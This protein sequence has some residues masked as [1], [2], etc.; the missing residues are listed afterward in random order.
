MRPL[1]PTPPC[2]VPRG[3]APALPG[4]LSPR[5]SP[6]PSPALSQ[7]RAPSSRAFPRRVPRG[8]G[9]FFSASLSRVHLECPPDPFPPGR[10][11]FPQPSPPSVPRGPCPLPPTLPAGCSPCLISPGPAYPTSPLMLGVPGCA[12]PLSGAPNWG[13]LECP[14]AAP[15]ARAPALGPLLAGGPARPRPL[16][17]PAVLGGALTHPG[18]G[19]PVL[20]RQ[21]AAGAECRARQ[22]D[23]AGP[24]GALR[25][26]L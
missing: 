21:R 15:W 4:L 23:E 20:K 10:R 13:H 24:T 18:P 19:W 11:S 16:P 14:P 2:R 9:P 25:A 8:P 1:S 3:L 6:C 7:A 17:V 5:F 22:E 12:P 26:L